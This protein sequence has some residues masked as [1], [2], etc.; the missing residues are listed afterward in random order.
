MC[1]RGAWLR[2][3][4]LALS[5]LRALGPLPWALSAAGRCYLFLCVFLISSNEFLRSREASDSC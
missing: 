3:G 2:S 1:T 4:E 5:A